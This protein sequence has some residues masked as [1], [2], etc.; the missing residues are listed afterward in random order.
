MLVPGPL[1]TAALLAALLLPLCTAC[2]RPPSSPLEAKGGGGEL[3]VILPAEPENLDPNSPRDEISLIVA[4]N[5]Y[6]RLLMLDA[7]SR[8]H[9]DLAESWEVGRDGREYT[10]HLR[11]GVLWHDGRPFEAADVQ[12]TFQHLAGRPGFAAEALRRIAAVQTPDE[13]T[14]VLRLREPWAPFLSTLAGNGTFILPRPLARETRES[15]RAAPVGTGPFRF[16]EWVPGRRIVLTANRSFFRRGPFLDRV[17]YLIE[18]DLTRGPALLVADQADYAV[19][20]PPPAV[21]LRLALDPRLKVVTSSTDGRYYLAFNL[22]RRPFS[23]HRVREAVNR[24]LDRPALLERA[25]FGYG[26]PALGFYTPAV[27]WA[28]NP[29]AQAP[30]FDP[31]R[32]RALLDAAGLRPDSRGIRLE[33]KFLCPTVPPYPEICQ[34]V[35]DQLRTAGI[36]VRLESIRPHSL[37]ERA[38]QNHDF[39]LIVIGGNQGPDP[40][41][42]NLRFGSHGNSQIMGYESPE[43]DAALAEGSRTVDLAN[44]ARAYFRAQKIL[45]RDLP[46][47]PLAEAV[48]VTLCRRGVT[49]LPRMEARGLVPE[50]ELS[51]VRVHPAV[52][53]GPR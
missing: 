50:N 41:N 37:M 47:A 5:L 14:V 3:R 44:R 24:V 42:L 2:S 15:G 35:A 6:N 19:L 7:D 13:H 21:L 49:G 10:F 29:A 12:W 18:P 52:Q 45:A 9:P 16:S 4:P 34:V 27:A 8:L 43:M 22:R 28:Y 38:F 26:A 1:R 32:A 51:L 48:N 39:D 40:E 53:R 46:I 11:Q 31:A 33:P 20:R 36:A 25:L 30:P 23:D 17:V